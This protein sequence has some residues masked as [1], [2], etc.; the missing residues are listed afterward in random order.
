MWEQCSHG[1]RVGDIL[2]YATLPTLCCGDS[3]TVDDWPQPQPLPTAYQ[4]NP[5]LLGPPKRKCGCCQGRNH[6]RQKKTESVS[7]PVT[8]ETK[9]TGLK[10]P[11]VSRG[12]PALTW[13]SS[14]LQAKLDAH[15]FR[16]LFKTNQKKKS[17]DSL[18]DT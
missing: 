2:S 18:L 12:N 6:G 13:F 10:L 3:L 4:L 5:E 17:K 11:S 15:V 1:A 7:H 9:N 14:G 16:L 8:A